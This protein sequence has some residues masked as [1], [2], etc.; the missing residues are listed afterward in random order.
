MISVS[1]GKVFH[2][3]PNDYNQNILPQKHN[4]ICSGKVY[5]RPLFCSLSHETKVQK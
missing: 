2:E 3:S 1:K 4:C 5:F